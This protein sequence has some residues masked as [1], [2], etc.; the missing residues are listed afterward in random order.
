MPLSDLHLYHFDE[1]LNLC[2]FISVG[3]EF[4]GP[5]IAR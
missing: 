3:G 4:G 5:S 2:Q 1:F